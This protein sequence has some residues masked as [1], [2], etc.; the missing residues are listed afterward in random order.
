MPLHFICTNRSASFAMKL[1]VYG[2][3]EDANETEML[4]CARDPIPGREWWDDLRKRV[5]KAPRDRKARNE[6]SVRHR[7]APLS[8]LAQF[9]RAMRV[10]W[11]HAMEEASRSH[12]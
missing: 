6:A 1:W 8:T 2:Q 5:D 7:V 3:C 12:L 4:S 11:G 9:T 10:G